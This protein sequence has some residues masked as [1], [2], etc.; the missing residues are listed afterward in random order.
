MWVDSDMLDWFRDR[1]QRDGR[2]YQTAIN[3]ALKV[4]AK[5]DHRPLPEVV[6][7]VVRAEVRAACAVK[8]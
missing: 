1:A 3:E 8:L 5:G 2:G 7:D 4:F 6:R